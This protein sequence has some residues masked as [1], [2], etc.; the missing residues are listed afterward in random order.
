MGEFLFGYPD[1]AETPYVPTIISPADQ[2]EVDQAEPV[3]LIW[4]PQGLVGSF[5]VQ[6]ATDA[7]FANL[8]VETNDLG[9]CSYV[10]QNPLPNTQYFW[11]VRVV[12]QGATSDWAPASFKTVS[13][14]LHLTYPAGGE[15][16]QRYQVVTIHW[17]ENISENVALDIYKGGL[18]NRNFVASVPSTGSY[19][20]TVGQFLAFPPGS[21]YTMKIRSTTDS[22]MYDFSPPFCL[23]TNLTSV[24]IGGNSLTILPDGR[25][26]FGFSIPGVLEATVLDSTNL[27]D[28]EVLQIVPLTNSS[29]VFTDETATNFPS[30][31][32][33]SACHDTCRTVGAGG[34]GGATVD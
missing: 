12:N 3:T 21:D 25:V 9:N 29:A 24:N 15:V 22:A 10:Q 26:Q 32:T 17:F 34:A 2:A 33:A 16:W 5:D 13:P 23:I 19:T 27:Q 28:W 14:V 8:V 7:A 6:V 31:F 11:R 4:R 18:S 20:W 1:L 30:R